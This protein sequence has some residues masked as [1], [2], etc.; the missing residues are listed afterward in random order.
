MYQ[1]ANN[2]NRKEAT[3]RTHTPSNRDIFFVG[4]RRANAGKHA[5]IF[6]WE[7]GA[8]FDELTGRGWSVRVYN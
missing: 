1:P 2:N 7:L 8:L 6:A 3:T 5:T 4:K